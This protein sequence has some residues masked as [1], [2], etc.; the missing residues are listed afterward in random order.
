MFEHLPVIS[1]DS[2]RVMV[3]RELPY[4]NNLLVGATQEAKSPSEVIERAFSVYEVNVTNPL[5][6]KAVKAAY[7]VEGG[8][9]AVAGL[10]AVLRLIDQELEAK[11]TP[12]SRI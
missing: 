3:E 6:V 8:M 11:V 4:F 9:A 10:L 5:L 12:K 1:E 7:G 2:L